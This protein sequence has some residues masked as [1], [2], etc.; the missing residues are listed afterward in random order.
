MGMR[1]PEILGD[2]C[3]HSHVGP[4]PLGFLLW[5]QVNTRLCTHTHRHT[6]THTDTHTPQ[7]GSKGEW[8]LEV[9]RGKE[10]R[11]WRQLG[12]GVWALSLGNM[13]RAIA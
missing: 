2:P 3:P 4:F 5:A 10:G 7:V 6:H 11:G 12:R 13:P 9:T 8:T 1:A